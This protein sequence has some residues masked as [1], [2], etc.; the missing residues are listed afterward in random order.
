MAKTSLDVICKLFRDNIQECL[1]DSLESITLFGSATGPDYISGV[2]DH[3]FLVIINESA[4]NDL[5]LVRKLVNGWKKKK[6][7]TPLFMTRSYIESSLDSFPIEFLNM[8]LSHRV[9]HGD[10]VLAELN[11]NAEDLR[12][13]A[14]R[15][16]K[17]YLLKLRQ[18]SILTQGKPSEIRR[19]I[20]ESL[21]AFTSLF[22]ALLY[23]K[24][25]EIPDTINAVRDTACEA[26]SLDAQ[27]FKKLFNLRIKSEK[28]DKGQIDS[29]LQQY[30]VEV[31]KLASIV[32]QFE[33]K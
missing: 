16:V 20:V 26:L 7:A 31:E 4:V 24:K 19:L 18:G 6:I 10:D 23:L 17:G 3:N 32:D 1:G 33:V 2:S 15:E 29:L 11:I 5:H 8:Q 25:T 9:I 14:E 22:K 30:M 21:A 12:L 27:L 13:Q 28:T